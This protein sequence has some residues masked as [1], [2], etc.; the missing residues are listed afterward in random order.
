VGL[1]RADAGRI[2]RRGIRAFSLGVIVDEHIDAE[3]R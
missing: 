2:V 3:Y 1:D